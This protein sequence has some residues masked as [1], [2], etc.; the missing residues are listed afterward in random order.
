MHLSRV[1]ITEST[2][3][4]IHE[5]DGPQAAVKKHEVDTKPR[6]VNAKPSLP[7]EKGKIITQFQQELGEALDERVLEI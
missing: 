5:D 3:L 1:R 7:T 4:Q 2:D 6:V